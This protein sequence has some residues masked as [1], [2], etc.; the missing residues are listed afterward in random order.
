MTVTFTAEYTPAG[1]SNGLSQEEEAMA[2][3][4]LLERTP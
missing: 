2:S 3:P 1:Q 4:T